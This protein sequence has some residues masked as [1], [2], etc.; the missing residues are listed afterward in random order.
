[1]EKNLKLIEVRKNGRKRVRSINH[2]PSRTQQQFKA[3]CDINNIM[4]KYQQTG[5]FLHVTKKTGR[6]ADFTE[7]K[8]Y[9]SMLDQVIVAQDA[10]ASLP[11]NIRLKFQNDPGQLISFLRDRKNHDEGVKLGLIDPKPTEPI[12]NKNEPND[13]KNIGKKHTDQKPKK[14]ELD[15]S[16]ES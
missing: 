1:M 3:E 7:I 13:Q 14:L 5:E 8:D 2:R 12:E 16:S 10:F 4:A 9:Q 6:F 15:D 11:A